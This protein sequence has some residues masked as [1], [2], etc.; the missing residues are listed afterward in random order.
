MS[1]SGRTK[2]RRWPQILITSALLVVGGLVSIFMFGIVTGTEFCPQTF[3]VR[4]F[5]YLQLPIVGV[6]VFGIDR[7]D[8]TP[9]LC[10]TLTTRGY[11][12]EQKGKKTWDLIET[13]EGPETVEA[14]AKILTSYLGVGFFGETIETEKW[15][16][17]NADLAKV[18]WPAVA[19]LA[20]ANVY[21]LMPELFDLRHEGQTEDELTAS[22]DDLFSTRLTELGTLQQKLGNAS[23]AG[24]IFALVL[25]RDPSNETARLGK[26]ECDATS[27]NADEDADDAEETNGTSEASAE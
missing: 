20:R 6:Q 21:F 17:K 4:R 23:F 24:E 13:S 22:I 19:D 10:S 15:T 26:A 27:K 8:E 16:Q 3:E 2:K 5:Q 14:D 25:K 7:V 12:L 9:S 1:N 11:V 18:F